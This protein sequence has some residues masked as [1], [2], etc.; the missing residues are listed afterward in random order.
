MTLQERIRHQA[1][2][3]E[4]ERDPEKVKLLAAELERLLEQDKQLKRME[5][6]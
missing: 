2:L 5:E 3:I 6:V 4:L 1:G